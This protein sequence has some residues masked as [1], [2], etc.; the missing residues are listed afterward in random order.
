MTPVPDGAPSPGVQFVT[1]LVADH[2]LAVDG[3]SVREVLGP[4]RITQVPRAPAA[5]AGLMNLR[6]EVITVIDLRRRFGFADRPVGGVPVNVIID[7]ARGTS[8]LLVDE[9]GDIVA[10]PPALIAEPPVTLRG[11]ARELIRGACQLDGRLLL[12]LDVAAALDV[13]S[14]DPPQTPRTGAPRP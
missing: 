10:V 6:G 14:D 12:C 8:S 13:L 4:Q 5:V 11:P 9:V 3:G 7:T 1:F 2:R